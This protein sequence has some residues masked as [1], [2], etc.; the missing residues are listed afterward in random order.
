MVGGEVR[1]TPAM[2][3]KKG[4]NGEWHGMIVTEYVS[5]LEPLWSVEFVTPNFAREE[6]SLEIYNSSSSIFP[7]HVAMDI[8]NVV[9]VLACDNV[10]DFLIKLDSLEEGEHSRRWKMVEFGGTITLKESE[11]NKE[12]NNHHEADSKTKMCSTRGSGAEDLRMTRTVNQRGDKGSQN[13]EVG[14]KN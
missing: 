14:D 8:L 12:C 6:V 7:L 3:K 1:S 9:I 13:K 10:D 4:L 11:I 5:K 2:T